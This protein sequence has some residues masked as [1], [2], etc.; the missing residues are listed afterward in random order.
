MG[1][2][3]ILVNES[4]GPD[5]LPIEDLASSFPGNQIEPFDPD[6]FAQRVR[7]A[8]ADGI[9]FVGVAGGDGTIRSVVDEILGTEAALLPIPAG[10]RNHFAR[11]LGIDDLA[12]AVAAAGP[13]G[14]RQA[15]DV[16]EVNDR[17]FLNNASIGLY[18]GLVVRREEHERVIPKPLANVIATWQELRRGR[19]ITVTFDDTPIRAWMMFVG[20][21]CYGD[22]IRDLGSRESLSDN[23]LDVRVV[24]ADRRASRLRVLSALMLG[25]LG[26]SPLI[27]RFQSSKVTVELQGRT[28]EVALDGE[29]E[30][31]PTPL[32]FRSRPLALTVLVPP[33]IGEPDPSQDPG[34]QPG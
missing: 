23:V 34:P 11:A 15:V 18:P 7:A 8:I 13:D 14:Q 32:C 4:S 28:A 33:T 2:G 22:S 24:R 31:I 6:T 1:A 27:L 30:T 17:Y 19:K 26:R 16:G 21:G 5:D 25:R 29:V 10:T 20:N 12:L 9:G 3:L